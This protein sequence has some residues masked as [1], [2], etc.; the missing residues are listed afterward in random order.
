M[1]SPQKGEY[2]PTNAPLHREA[3]ARSFANQPELS[4]CAPGDR[5]YIFGELLPS[6][7][8]ALERLLQYA[9]R[10][11]K[12]PTDGQQLPF[13][14]E[15]QPVDP[16]NWLAQFLFRNNPRFRDAAGAAAGGAA[17]GK[18]GDYLSVLQQM[19]NAAREEQ[20]QE[21]ERSAAANKVTESSVTTISEG[22]ANAVMDVSQTRP[23]ECDASTPFETLET[24]QVAEQQDAPLSHT[25]NAASKEE[26]DKVQREREDS[27][28]SRPSSQRS[29]RGTSQ[30]A[31]DTDSGSA[32][33]HE[34]H[35]SVLRTLF[36]DIAS[37]HGPTQKME[38]A[39]LRY[40]TLLD[41]CAKASELTTGSTKDSWQRYIQLLRYP[42][43]AKTLLTRKLSEDEFVEHIMSIQQGDNLFD[44][45]MTSMRSVLSREEQDHAM[46]FRMSSANFADAQTAVI[47]EVELMARRIDVTPSMLLRSAVHKLA[48]ELQPEHPILNVYVSLSS[49]VGTDGAQILK[50]VAATPKDESLVLD[51]FVTSAD[52]PLSFQAL[53]TGKSMIVGDIRGSG[54]P[55]KVFGDR[56]LDSASLSRNGS[57]LA[58]P[59][60]AADGKVVGLLAA[61]TLS[62][63]SGPVRPF[64]A[65]D[66]GLFE[67]VAAKLSEAHAITTTRANMME[68]SASAARWMS[69]LTGTPSELYIVD[70]NLQGGDASKQLR[71]YELGNVEKAFAAEDD[72][73][74][75]GL[76][77]DGDDDDSDADIL[78]D[79]EE[80]DHKEEDTDA[81]VETT[82]KASV[83]DNSYML[84]LESTPDRQFVFTAAE[85]QERTDDVA[86]SLLASPI[87][88]PSGRV[89]AVITHGK[90]T[91]S[92]AAG[93][94]ATESTSVQRV[95]TV[96]QEGL[97]LV[98]GSNRSDN[99]QGRAALGQ[100]AASATTE[101]M[102][103]LFA[104]LLYANVRE[105]L[106]KIDARSIAELRSYKSP[107]KVIHTVL[108]SVLYLFGGK[109][110]D[111]KFWPNVS[112]CITGELLEKMLQ[113]DPRGVQKK[114]HFSRV[115]KALKRVPFNEVQQQG[116]RPA[117]DSRWGRSI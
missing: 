43:S 92:G 25:N 63:V 38:L 14:M 52:V 61:D 72:G 40:H 84:A 23:G 89:F 77:G 68:L 83:S 21:S 75:D 115:R 94:K 65:R 15:H 53:T 112:R 109:P 96:L 35:A 11:G 18:N 26:E 16:V 101:D 46:G 48:T 17:E 22:A 69:D 103:E 9:E 110:R 71:K 19:A 64:N 106:S 28:T 81:S 67:A 30:Q 62:S 58:V 36:A 13:R 57:F 86:S 91:G 49:M 55:V 47:K 37:D 56:Q 116:S 10:S 6:V 24:T 100:T 105:S 29:R 1:P 82:A 85:K 31:L 97:A 39:V 87:L 51:Q 2:D 78:H 12:V 76:N 3:I 117:N 90:D 32:E 79:N 93:E 5:A 44:E 27:V 7:V 99:K 59:L 73:S 66:I 74:V 33:Q 45:L 80:G 113:Y 70:H 42:I 54:T 111:L 4:G 34:R 95:L 108:K 41:Q 50:Y 114:V 60:R 107:P 8:P 98:E 88:D 102:P 104:R 20:K